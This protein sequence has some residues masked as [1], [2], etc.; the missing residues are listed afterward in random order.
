[1][2]LS[3]HRWPHVGRA[4]RRASAPPFLGGLLAFS[5]AL[6][7]V[8]VVVYAGAVP[9]L[10]EQ[11]PLVHQWAGASRARA[12]GPDAPLAGGRGLPNNGVGSSEMG[13]GGDAQ[14]ASAESTDPAL[15]AAAGES[16]NPT[17]ILLLGGRGTTLLGGSGFGAQLGGGVNALPRS[18]S[19]QRAENST[20]SSDASSSGSSANGSSSAGAGA[21]PSSEASS[22]GGSSSGSN[23]DGGSV[24]NGSEGGGSSGG[25]AVAPAPSE[26]EP[27]PTIPVEAGGPVPEAMEQRIC[28]ALRSEYDVLQAQAAKVRECAAT[29]EGLCMTRPLEPRIEAARAVS[30]VLREVQLADSNMMMEV[31]YACDREDGAMYGASRY[32]GNF[33]QMH[34]SYGDLINLMY[35]LDNAWS[36]NCYFE[37]PAANAD[38]WS[39]R[40]TRNAATGRM[41]Y[42]EAYEADMIGARP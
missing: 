32:S 29:Y 35:E 33:N 19:A 16:S 5:L 31:G 38:Y 2:E 21:G 37:D 7:V 4:F 30:G 25:N 28:A 10:A 12:F 18:A 11:S 27:E 1:M 20:A 26:P 24:S 39:G 3:I 13:G 34:Q 6:M 14:S 40:V 23:S 9:S 15:A 36:G 8:G 42:L 22:S 17:D 41:S